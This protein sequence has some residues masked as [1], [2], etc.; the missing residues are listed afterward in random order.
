MFSLFVLPILILYRSKT[1]ASSKLSVTALSDISVIHASVEKNVEATHNQSSDFALF[2]AA[3]H[4]GCG[5]FKPI[6][7]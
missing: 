1:T 4:C 3:M 5:A 2:F 7:C 6:A